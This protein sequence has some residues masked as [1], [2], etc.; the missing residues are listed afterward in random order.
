MWICPCIT[1]H[2]ITPR[3]MMPFCVEELDRVRGGHGP[4]DDEIGEGMGATPK[5]RGGYLVAICPH[6]PLAFNVSS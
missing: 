4:A 1:G 6:L 3:L 5:T 2:S